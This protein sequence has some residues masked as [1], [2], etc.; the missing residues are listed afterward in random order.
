M[1]TYR[2]ENITFLLSSPH[3]N[4]DMYNQ[5]IIHSFKKMRTYQDI[6]QHHHGYEVKIYDKPDAYNERAGKSHIPPLQCKQRR[7][8][9]NDEVD[10]LTSR[11]KKAHTYSRH[12]ICH[13]AP[14]QM[15]FINP[16]TAGSGVHLATI[17]RKPHRLVI[18]IKGEV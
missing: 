10:M 17:Y 1:F 2:Y 15:D 7:I 12:E 14:W 18:Y 11:C 5:L 8:Y 9:I 16:I 4:I 3:S 6:T 13:N